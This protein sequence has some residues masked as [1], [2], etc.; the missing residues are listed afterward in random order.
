M[1]KRGEVEHA[2]AQVNLLKEV[3]VR[4]FRGGYQGISVPLGKTG[5]RYRVGSGRGRMVAVGAQ[6]QIADSG[7]LC[8][9][10]SRAVFLGS[11]KTLEFAFSKLVNLEVFSDGLRF[12]VSNRQSAS[13]FQ[14]GAPHIVAAVVQAA[15][16][17][18][19]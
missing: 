2:E 7:W 8:I 3:A 16:R 11:A 1:L 5:V 4:E 10:S 17:R 12:H 19:Q 15:F 13:L 6:L 18:A 14:L 9:S